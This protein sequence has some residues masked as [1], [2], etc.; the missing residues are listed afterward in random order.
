[1]LNKLPNT[2]IEQRGYGWDGDYAVAS[3]DSMWVA[4]QAATAA[5]RE[6]CAAICDARRVGPMSRDQWLVANDCVQAIRGG[7]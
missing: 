3:V 7:E 2:R 1:M 6:R 4:W 5:E